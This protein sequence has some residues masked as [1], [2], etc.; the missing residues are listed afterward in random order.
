MKYQIQIKE[1][2]LDSLLKSTDPD[3][4]KARALSRDIRELEAEADQEQRNYEF[5]TGK[6]NPGYQ[7]GNSH[8]RNSYGSAGRSESG[9][10][11]GYG[12][13]MEGYGQGR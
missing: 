9:G 8:G 6:M 4:E 3:L 7:S 10:M 12:R 5:E 11:M 1:K 2:E 13:G